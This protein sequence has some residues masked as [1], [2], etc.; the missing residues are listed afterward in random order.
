MRNL[1]N[2]RILITAGPT[3]VAIDKV[4]VLSNIATGETGIVLAKALS[5]QGAKVTM[6]LGP[7][8]VCSLDKK[9]KVLRFNYFDE[10]KKTLFKELKSVKYD[11]LIHSAAV[12]DYRPKEIYRGKI[13]SNL[14]SLDIKLEPLPKIINLIKILEK[15]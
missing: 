15:D 5:R 3:W 11:C 10:F 7:C 4:R 12:S 2:K 1:K 13:G 14:K 6:I 9:I 8:G